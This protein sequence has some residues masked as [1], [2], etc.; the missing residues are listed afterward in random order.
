MRRYGEWMEVHISKGDY[1]STQVKQTGP[2]SF[3]ARQNEDCC[4]RSGEKYQEMRVFIQDGGGGGYPVIETE[5][6]AFD[7][8]EE[9]LSLLEVMRRLVDDHV[10]DPDAWPDD[11][12]APIPSTW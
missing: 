8:P 2:R 1:Q 3:V 11:P 4:G 10:D 12:G 7:S 9:L 5:R 6:F